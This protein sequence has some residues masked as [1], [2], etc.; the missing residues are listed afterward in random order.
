[1]TSR[2]TGFIPIEETLKEAMDFEY[3]LSSLIESSHVFSNSHNQ[4]KEERQLD[5]CK[6]FPDHYLEE[7]VSL[8]AP[9]NSCGGMKV[10]GRVLQIPYGPD[11]V[12]VNTYYPC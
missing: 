11:L 4:N 1:M 12:K 9:C 7:N 3:R 10:V 8:V 5:Y 2:V 6:C